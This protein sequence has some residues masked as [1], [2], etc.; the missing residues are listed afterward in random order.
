MLGF[1]VWAQR[2]LSETERYSQVMFRRVSESS[3][4]LNKPNADVVAL[5]GGAL[6]AGHDD[7]G[8][9][10]SDHEGPAHQHP[11]PSEPHQH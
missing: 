1:V 11:D 2:G 8:D 4:G 3:S 7:S 5:M 9:D 6:D 10:G